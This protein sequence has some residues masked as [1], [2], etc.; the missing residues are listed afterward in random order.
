MTD[1]IWGG[2]KLSHAY[3]VLDIDRPV[4]R[5]DGWKGELERERDVVAFSNPV[6]EER[7]ARNNTDFLFKNLPSEQAGVF[8]CLP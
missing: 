2:P 8:R 4:K 3:F 1:R 6:T 5:M 7:L